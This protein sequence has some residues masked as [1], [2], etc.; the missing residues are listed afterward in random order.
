MS[1]SPATLPMPASKRSLLSAVVAAAVLVGRAQCEVFGA[2][3]GRGVARE[4][5]A[6]ITRASSP[7]TSRG[8]GLGGR[9]DECGDHEPQG[10]AAKAV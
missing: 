5:C 2:D 6:W 9:R 10:N 1:A 3:N 8:T 4:A 7:F